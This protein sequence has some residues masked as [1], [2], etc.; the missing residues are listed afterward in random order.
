MGQDYKRDMRASA[1][2]HLNA[3]E[4]L[5]GTHRKDIAGYLLGWAAECALKYM[6]Q[7]AGIK[8]LPPSQRQSDPYYAHFESVKTL[9]ADSLQGRRALKGLV[10]IRDATGFLSAVLATDVADEEISTAEVGLR[11]VLGPYA[12]TDALLRNCDGIGAARLLEEATRRP[13]VKVRDVEL[14][15][16]DRRVVGLDWLRAPEPSTSGSPRI[17]FWS[18]KGGVGRTTALCVIASHL[19]RLGLRVLAVDFD[20]EAPGIGTML[21][22]SGEVPAFGALDYLV[23]SGVGLIGDDFIADMIGNSSLG[24][25]GARVAVIPA[26]G[27]RTLDN[28]QN[29][30]SKLARA[31]IEN[32]GDEG[33][34]LTLSQQL[35]G[36]LDRVEKSGAF[37]VILVDARAGLHESV[38]AALLG[39]GAETLLFGIDQPQT[40]LGYTLLFAHLRQFEIDA[41]DDWRDRL[42]FVQAKASGRDDERREAA[43]RFEALYE[44][45]TVSEPA[46]FSP[47]AEDLSAEDFAMA[48]AEDEAVAEETGFE[49]SPVT[50]II[51]DGR[52]RDFDPLKNGDLLDPEVYQLSFRPLLEMVDSLVGLDSPGGN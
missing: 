39:L 32:V 48:W 44:L 26:V 6:M 41:E 38:A 24:S 21:L 49:P 10:V 11:E 3:A 16:L 37:D 51:E 25:K 19:S 23:E 12:R 33:E 13:L 28:P 22:A 34:S 45:V 27:Q 31:Y 14:Q 7:Q 18:L 43:Q 5:I 4:L 2:R 8:E 20:L 29:A 40:F 17:V 46:D 36:L 47:V 35:S 9:L 52:Y 42:H 1:H 30:L 15:L 50:H